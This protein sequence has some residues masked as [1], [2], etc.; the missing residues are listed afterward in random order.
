MNVGIIGLGRMGYAIAQR[1]LQGGHAVTGYDPNDAACQQAQSAGISS[2][3]SLEEI[4]KNNSVIWLMIPA[5]SLIDETIALLLK[6]VQAG[7]IIIDGG[8]SNYQDSMRRASMLK[9]KNISFLDCGT[10]GGLHGQEFGFS[11]MVGGEQNAY[12]TVLP[13]FTSI[14]APG[15]VIRVGPSGTGHYVKM[16]HNGIEYGLL[17]AYAEG[18]QL[19]KEGTFKEQNL[20]LK[21]ISNVWNNGAVIRSWILS[22]AHDVFERDQNFSTISGAIEE[23]G[24][25]RWTVQEAHKNK[26]PVP[27][28][29]KSLEVREWSRETGGNYAT[30]IVA[31][32]R[33]AFGGHAVKKKGNS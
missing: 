18:F 32:L 2:A 28:I 17:Q 19:M 7:T 20:D 5:G 1:A 24:T 33:H 12:D 11:L 10:S 27:V 29:E 9:Q 8:N 15:G 13:L 23:S 26:I 22:L 3:A 16:V 25:G 31:L 30:K 4:A 6:H 21:A 14:A